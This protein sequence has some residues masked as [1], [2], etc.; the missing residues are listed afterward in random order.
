MSTRW[1]RL[2]GD[3]SAF[4]LK[5]A[6]ASDPDDVRYIDPEVGLSWGSFQIWVGGRNL[7][8]H[9][10][11]GERI[12]SVHWYLLPLLEWFSRNWNPLLHEERFPVENAGDTGWASLRAT[13][14][15]PPA[16]E[17]NEQ[18]TSEWEREWQ[19][20]WTR[21]AIHTASEGGLFPDVVFRRFRDLVEVSWGPTHAQGMPHHYEFMESASGVGRIAPQSVA[22]PLHEVLSSA[23]EYLLSL[24]PKSKRFGA[25]NRSLRALKRSSG[26]SD[27]GDAPEEVRAALDEMLTTGISKDLKTS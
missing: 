17:A 7:C 4:A 5:V 18:Q 6:F 24:K 21:H 13:R 22:D 23:S 19:A 1:E 10:E 12:D 9:L 15:P 25:L 14:F 11:E 3:T 20:W 26:S 8:A 2:A 16:I 27:D